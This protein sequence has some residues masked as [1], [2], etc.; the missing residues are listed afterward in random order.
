MKLST[1]S[2]IVA[3]A[4]IGFIG[5]STVPRDLDD[6]SLNQPICGSDPQQ[7]NWKDCHRALLQVSDPKQPFIQP[8]GPT[9]TGK[10]NSC[11][12]TLATT[13]NSNI[14]VPWTSVLYR[15]DHQ[16]GFQV[17]RNTCG[18]KPGS[19]RIKG[20][21]SSTCSLTITFACNGQNQTS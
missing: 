5:A 8:G 9:V 4:S 2:L 16:S 12:V 6:Q 17:Y 20:G 1:N 11:A 13:D 7:L 18:T 14:S 21:S 10:F 3:L 19:I 15:P